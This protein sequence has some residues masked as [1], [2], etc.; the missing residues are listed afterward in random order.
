MAHALILPL[1]CVSSTVHAD[2]FQPDQVAPLNPP[3]DYVIAADCM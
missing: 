1:L 2:W 3:F